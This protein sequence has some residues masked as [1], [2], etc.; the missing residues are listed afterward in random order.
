M[1]NTLRVKYVA[2][3]SNKIKFVNRKEINKKRD[4]RKDGRKNK[5]E[6]NEL[7]NRGLK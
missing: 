1:L 3:L 5:I 6:I 2:L 4:E 7:W